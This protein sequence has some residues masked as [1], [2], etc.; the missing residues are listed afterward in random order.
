V[1]DYSY[2]SVYFAYLMFFLVLG[3]SIYFCIHSRKDGYWGKDSE[4]VKYRMMDD[5]A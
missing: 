1:Q 4:E 2:P 5:E 3:L